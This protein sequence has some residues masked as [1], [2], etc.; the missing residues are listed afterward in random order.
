MS[1]RSNLRGLRILV[2]E[3]TVLIA[4]L[5]VDQLEEA[6]CSVVGPASH[7]AQGLALAA[8]EPIDGALLDVNL[9]GEFCFPIAKVLVERGI[10]IAFLTGYGDAVLAEEYQNAPR[11]AKPFDLDELVDLMKAHFAR[12]A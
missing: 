8:A 9:N 3:D 4:D 10:P 6:G 7:V 2:V 5:I 1:D 11:L 12:A